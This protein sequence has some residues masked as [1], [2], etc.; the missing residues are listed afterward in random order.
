MPKPEMHPVKSSNIEAIGHDGDALHVQYRGGGTYTYA[1]VPEST[2]HAAR[3]AARSA[4]SVG[5]FLHA[6]IKGQYD[7]AKLE[8]EASDAD[9]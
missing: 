8:P 6:N 9:D 7:H 3:S 4:E 5:R 1:G 2:F